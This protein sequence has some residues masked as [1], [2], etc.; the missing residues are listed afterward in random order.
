MTTKEQLNME[1]SQHSV[2][3]IHISTVG[4]SGIIP[5]TVNSKPSVIYG[6]MKQIAVSELSAEESKSMQT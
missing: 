3:A 1:E 4:H 5:T 2:V 6:R